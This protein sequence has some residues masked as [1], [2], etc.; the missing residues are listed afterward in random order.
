MFN[1]HYRLSTFFDRIIE[2][3]RHSVCE[4]IAGLQGSHIRMNHNGL[5]LETLEERIVLDGAPDAFDH[6]TMDGPPAGWFD[7]STAWAYFEMGDCSCYHQDGDHI[8]VYESGADQ[9]WWF[10]PSEQQWEQAYEW[11]QDNTT[12][13][14]LDTE[15]PG[16][17][18]WA[19]NQ[20]DGTYYY[21]DVY[22]GTGVAYQD[23]ATGQ[24]FWYDQG[25]DQ[26]WSSDGSDWEESDPPDALN[27]GPT[28]DVAAIG[29]VAEDSGLID[30][31]TAFTVDDPDSLVLTVTVTGSTGFDSLTVGNGTGSA[32]V[33]Q[34][35]ATDW[36]VEGSID[37]VNA[38]LDTL[39]G[40]LTGD[41]EGTAEVDISVSDG[42]TATSDALG[43]TVDPVQDDPVLVLTSPAP[44]DEDGN[45]VDL[46]DAIRIEDP[47]VGDTIEV[48]IEALQGY[49]ALNLT[50]VPGVVITQIGP[51]HVH[52]SGSLADVNSALATLTGTLIQD[53]YGTARI[54][55][56]GSDGRPA[57]ND[58]GFVDLT[59]NSQNDPP[60][61]GGI[62]DVTVVEDAANTVINLYN[63][64]ADTEDAD[65][66][67]VYTI[68]GNT[69]AGL[70]SDL[71]ISD[72]ANFTLDYAP[73]ANGTADI[74]IRAADTGG[75]WA[76][77]TF[78]VTV[79]PVNDAPVL[80]NA[81]DMSLN[82]I[83]EDISP[84]ANT[85][86]TVAD[87]I[88][89]AGG[90]RITDVDTGALEGIAITGID[91]TN[92]FWQYS[93]NGGTDWYTVISVAPTNALLL[94]SVDIVRFM[95]DSDYYGTVGS[96]ITFHAWDQTSGSEGNYVDASTNG[97]ATA[98]SVSTETASITVNP[99]NDAPVLDNTG[100]MF[101]DAIDEDIDPSS[102]AGNTVAEIIASAGGDRI[103]DIDTGALEGIAITGIDNTHGSWQYRLDGGSTWTDIS[104]SAATDNALLLGSTDLVRFMPDTDYYGTV[105]PGITFHAWDRTSGSAGNY[106]DAST[107]G[108]TSAFSSATETASITVN[109]V[110]DGQ[111]TRYGSM[112]GNYNTLRLAMGDLD[113]DND[114]DIVE[115]VPNNDASY[116]H[117]NDGNGNYTQTG[118]ILDHDGF[119]ADWQ[120]D[121]ALGD[122][123]GDNDLDIVFANYLGDP[124]T[125]W[126]NDGTGHFTDTG[127]RLG[128]FDTA[129]VLLIDVDNDND[130]DMVTGNETQADRVYLN[131]GLGVFL[132]Y[133]VS[134]G[135]SSTYSLASGDLNGDGYLDVVAGTYNGGIMTYLNLGQTPTG[136]WAGFSA[137]SGHVHTTLTNDIGLADVNGNNRLDLIEAN[138]GENYVYFGFGDGTFYDSGQTLGNIVY[139]SNIALADVDGDGDIDFIAANGLVTSA[140]NR[141]YL[142]D[143][144]G[145]F[146]TSSVL[147][148]GATRAVAL[149]DV[150]GDMKD[151]VV[152]GDYYRPNPIWLNDYV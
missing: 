100:D 101:L 80:D 32:T 43:V 88:L 121:I 122:V 49:S 60:T 6:V 40:T 66:D 39:T 47:D 143:G 71:D 146:G 33:S 138:D 69:N 132:E 14:V 81:G 30:L 79:D 149:G 20:L 140:A 13:R 67:L 52:V 25:T 147:G 110:P 19:Y 53:F 63:S 133:G 10:D 123:D 94:R 70:F 113:G 2:P 107:N 50:P 97:G 120:E 115:S 57:A 92:G 9:W 16:P 145:Y 82:A 117:L 131:N 89:S 78:T 137:F 151:D 64:F 58:T 126:T 106:D 119:F 142:N 127:Q 34:S 72:P 51:S 74:T 99:V 128:T 15:V 38:A 48:E 135:S 129:A 73:N 77:T 31:G 27:E 75:L 23:H 90:D 21:R 111:F 84:T 105:D 144:F 61:T 125:V 86:T 83:D 118:Q 114:L 22:D 36:T 8:F 103:T 109:N 76:E 7:A 85:G 148:W 4:L 35:G 95:P 91:N 87:I 56:T 17:S 55:V 141:L 29:A 45:P 5:Q 116:V 68:E 46:N 136:Q 93:L 59:V 104:T 37:D 24:W 96:G 44:V 1:A 130:L 150:N 11:F 28:V 124:N 54:N 139:T 42:V 3:V 41:F 26:W 98:F 62:A 65:A 152:Y 112:S 102:N 108:G 12:M 134:Y 18:V